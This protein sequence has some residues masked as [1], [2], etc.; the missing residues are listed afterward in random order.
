MIDQ[1]EMDGMSLEEIEEWAMAVLWI[2]VDY[3]LR[4]R[5]LTLEPGALHPVDFSYRS[6]LKL[7]VGIE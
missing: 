5:C 6:K 7:T 2:A 4:K 3:N 1:L